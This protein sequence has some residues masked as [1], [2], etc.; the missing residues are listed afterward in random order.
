MKLKLAVVSLYF[1]ASS[2]FA[3]GHQHVLLTCV[4]QEGTGAIFCNSGSEETDITKIEVDRHCRIDV[5]PTVPDVTKTIFQPQPM[6]G[7]L[8]IQVPKCEA[9]TNWAEDAITIW[10]R[11]GN[12]YSE[13]EDDKSSGHIFLR[14][15]YQGEV[16]KLI[17]A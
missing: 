9:T 15:N 4:N 1:V 5:D 3:V 6:D 7:N 11:E 17:D 8:S 16:W 13:G 12:V 14:S 2:A 10:T